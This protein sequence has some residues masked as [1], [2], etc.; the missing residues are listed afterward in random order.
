MSFIRFESLWRSAKYRAIFMPRE[1]SVPVNPARG[2][3]LG[4]AITLLL[5][6]ALHGISHES[7][8]YVVSSCFPSLIA[9]TSQNLMG[10][11]EGNGI[12]R[13]PRRFPTT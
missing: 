10:L 9:L 2:N 1:S 12:Q 4:P 11:Q 3:K 7:T 8:E 13:P 6:A 5:E